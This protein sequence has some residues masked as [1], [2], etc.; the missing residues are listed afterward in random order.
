MEL[1]NTQ[2]GLIMKRW[3]KNSLEKRDFEFKKYILWAVF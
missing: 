1:A 2:V 3:R